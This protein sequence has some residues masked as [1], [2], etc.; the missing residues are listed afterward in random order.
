MVHLTPDELADASVGLLDPARAT[1]VAEHLAQCAECTAEAA[2]LD[3]VTALL[4]AEPTPPM[5]AAVTAR[6]AG[7]IAAESRL[8]SEAR[9]PAGSGPL[10]PATLAAGKPSLGKFGENLR[11]GS[12]SLFWSKIVMAAIAAGLIG[13]GGYVVSAAAGLNEPGYD[14][15]IAIDSNQLPAAAASVR[16]A[17]ELESHPFTRAWS[18]ARKAT[19]GR[20]DGLVPAL[21]DGNPGLLVYT[22][23]GSGGTRAAAV[24]GCASGTPTVDATAALPR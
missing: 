20:I 10:P 13:F 11:K 2:A 14:A 6:L 9:P 24:T 7:V 18:C 5:P 3:H 17:T 12:R 15:A 8:R 1:E 4:A 21:V 23:T 22:R 19:D 16:A